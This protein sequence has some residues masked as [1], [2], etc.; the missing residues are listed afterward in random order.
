LTER[1]DALTEARDRDRDG[2]AAAIAGGVPE[3]YLVEVERESALLDAELIWLGGL[4]DRIRRP[5]YPWGEHVGI[6]TDRY[7]AQREAARQ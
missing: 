7:L 4:I 1:L 5:D 6:P 3:L 2:R